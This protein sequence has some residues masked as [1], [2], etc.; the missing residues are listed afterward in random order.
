MTDQRFAQVVA[1]YEKLVYTICYQFTHNHHTAQDL[2]QETFLSAYT[3]MDGCPED[4]MKPWLARIATNKAKDHLK[5]AYNRRVRPPGED[6]LPEDA[7]VLY[8]SQQQPE[9]LAVGREELAGLEAEIR[10]LKEPYHKVAVLYFLEE[11]GVDEIAKGLERPPK[12][13]HTQLYR[14][15]KLLQ[16]KIGKGG[17]EDGTVS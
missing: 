11:K 13:V 12:T 10:A 8:I 1:Q 4:N 16:Q 3:H 17:D 6:G 5:S 2:A 7:K 15:K 14:A 9:D